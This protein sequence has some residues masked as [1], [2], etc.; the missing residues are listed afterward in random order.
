MGVLYT[1]AVIV[2]VCSAHGR[3]R[4]TAGS[5]LKN[6]ASIAR[7]NL[8]YVLYQPWFCLCHVFDCIIPIASDQERIILLFGIGYF[9]MSVIYQLVRLKTCVFKNAQVRIVSERNKLLARRSRR[10]S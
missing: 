6:A 3:P 8:V 10:I 2:L 1:R 5:I 9:G 7:L 4:L